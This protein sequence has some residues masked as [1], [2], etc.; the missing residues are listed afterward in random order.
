MIAARPSAVSF[1]LCLPVAEPLG[2]G[3]APGYRPRQSNGLARVILASAIRVISLR[4]E[5]HSIIF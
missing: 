2:P 1:S 5:Y 4:K 3:V